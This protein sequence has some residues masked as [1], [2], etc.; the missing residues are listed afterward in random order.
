V[1]GPRGV[2]LRHSVSGSSVAVVRSHE[3]TAV[4]TA[5]V[6]RLLSVVFECADPDEEGRFWEAMLGYARHHSGPDWVTIV[7]VADPTQR[8]S[9]QRVEDHVEPTWPARDRPQQAHIDLL[10]DDLDSSDER[11]IALGARRLTD[12]AVV[13]E[14]ESFQVYA[15]P[16]GHPFCLIVQVNP[17]L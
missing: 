8:L 12:H 11:A 2:S 3:Q 10:V 9:F 14:D 7:D 13:H 6:G 16:A 15:D 17:D 1:A 4:V 5:P